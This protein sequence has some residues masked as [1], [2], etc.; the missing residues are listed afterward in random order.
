MC[1]S[2][3]DHVALILNESTKW[4]LKTRSMYSVC[5]SQSR[6]LSLEYLS[7]HIC[8]NLPAARVFASSGLKRNG[9][10]GLFM[11]RSMLGSPTHHHCR[12]H[13]L[14]LHTLLLCHSHSLVFQ[15]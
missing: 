12:H 9:Q 7:Y 10:P 3:S 15:T 14:W 5:S 13:S 4:T 1:D 11:C 8:C 6:V 2:S